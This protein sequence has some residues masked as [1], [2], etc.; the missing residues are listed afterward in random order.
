LRGIAVIREAVRQTKV[1][2]RQGDA[3]AR[4]YFRHGGSCPACN[5]VLFHGDECRVLGG[6]AQD[7]FDIQWL[8]KAHVDHRGV[9]GFTRQ[10]R[11]LQDV[12]ERQNRQ[13][14]VQSS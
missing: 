9:E 2:N 3:C 1:Q 8:Y 11:L 12:P 14:V 4:Q 10:K 13:P 5:D 6:K 7:Q